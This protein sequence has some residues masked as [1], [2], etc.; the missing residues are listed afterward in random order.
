MVALGVG[1]CAEWPLSKASLA[2][3]EHWLQFRDCT[4][5]EPEA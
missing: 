4:S 2:A 3:P 1:A 5:D